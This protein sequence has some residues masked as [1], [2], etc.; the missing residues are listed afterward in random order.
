M[1][2][3][4]DEVHS[5]ETRTLTADDRCTRCGAQAYVVTAHMNGE[6]K[7]CRHHFTEHAPAL[8]NY[9]VVDEMEKLT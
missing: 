1:A 7:W 6:L 5:M 4:V 3:P 9:V 8:A 2:T